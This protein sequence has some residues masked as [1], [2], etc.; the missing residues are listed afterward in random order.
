MFLVKLYECDIRVYAD[1]I[2]DK[3][4][5]NS[6]I[7]Y[8]RRMSTNKHMLRDAKVYQGMLVLDKYD[9][10]ILKE[11]DSYIVIYNGEKR[12]ELKE[13]VYDTSITPI[14]ML[15]GDGGSFNNGGKNV[16]LPI[17]S[18]Y[19]YIAHTYPNIDPELNQALEDNIYEYNGGA[20]PFLHHSGSGAGPIDNGTNNQAELSAIIYGLDDI[21]KNYIPNN[22]TYPIPVIVSSDSQYVINGCRDW[23][24]NWNMELKSPEDI[25]RMTNGEMWKKL[26]DFINDPRLDI[27]FKWQRGHLEEFDNDDIFA[28]YNMYVDKLC[29]VEVNRFLEREYPE[30]LSEHERKL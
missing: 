28:T 15:H 9:L 23:I 3:I 17:F 6:N 16:N 19:A 5:D 22:V 2:V 14:V 26:F 29:N 20:H 1:P 12:I 18:T 24:Y 8:K 21:V 4:I 27:R 11:L 10:R 7:S 25:I 13:V 30:L